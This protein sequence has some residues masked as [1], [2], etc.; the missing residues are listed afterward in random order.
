[1]EKDAEGLL[2]E[3]DRVGDWGSYGVDILQG[4]YGKVPHCLPNEKLSTWRLLSELSILR[5]PK[6]M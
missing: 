5:G 6:N 1:V 4:G 3:Q 2:E